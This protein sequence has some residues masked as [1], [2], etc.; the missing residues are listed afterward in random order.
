M[1]ERVGL[2]SWGPCWVGFT[3]DDLYPDG[4]FSANQ[5]CVAVLRKNRHH[6]AVSC[7]V[8]L[9]DLLHEYQWSETINKSTGTEGKRH[10][11]NTHM[12]FS[13][14]VSSITNIN[15]SSYVKHK[16]FHLE[17]NVFRYI[18]SWTELSSLLICSQHK[19]IKTQAT[20]YIHQSNS[21]NYSLCWRA[22]KHRDRSLFN[23]WNTS[24]LVM[25]HWVRQLT[26]FELCRSRGFITIKV[27]LDGWLSKYK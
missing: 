17:E 27:S 14:G 11:K 4:T 16:P 20:R 19:V 5:L 2:Q 18:C 10:P 13:S 12:I 23:L 22:A 21:S 24:S 7:V 15:N 3:S 26:D 6:S 9:D 25:T 1:P 8:S